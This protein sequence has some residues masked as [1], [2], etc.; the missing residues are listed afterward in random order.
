MGMAA[1]LICAVLIGKGM[2]PISAM[3]VGYAWPFVPFSRLALDGK[4]YERA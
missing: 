1:S 2:H 3:P 4:K